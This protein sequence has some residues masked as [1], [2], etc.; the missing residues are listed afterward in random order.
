METPDQKAIARLQELLETSDFAQLS[1]EDQLWVKDHFG[2]ATYDELKTMIHSSR[3]IFARESEVLK[4]IPGIREQLVSR[5]HQV[6]GHK[7][8]VKT[9][10]LYNF[11][12]YKIRL[13]VA[14]PA[15][16][17]L[18][19]IA[20]AFLLR[21]NQSGKVEVR[22]VTITDTVYVERLKE[23]AIASDSNDYTTIKERNP[24]KIK[25]VELAEQS[26][27]DE[28]QGQIRNLG[29]L[30]DISRQSKR[31]SSARDDST[32]LKLL[33]TVN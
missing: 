27:P 22:T 33:V 7:Q 3:K 24:H 8:P 17:V 9:G 19:L 29:L 12:Q 21:M 30:T 4:A 11:L 13:A 20:F 18:I 23:D 28:I 2:E 15:A 1:T 32:L 16:I 31:G 10:A 6:H 14:L 25:P 26:L 5:F